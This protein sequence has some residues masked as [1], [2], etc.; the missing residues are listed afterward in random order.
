MS[1]DVARIK[2]VSNAIIAEVRRVG[3]QLNNNG[4]NLNTATHGSSTLLSPMQDTSSTTNPSAHATIPQQANATQTDWPQPREHLSDFMAMFSSVSRGVQP[5]IT[6]E[7]TLSTNGMEAVEPFP[8][9][10]VAIRKPGEPLSSKKTTEVPKTLPQQGSSAVLEAAA[11]K[12]NE[13]TDSG[14]VRPP[15]ANIARRM[16]Q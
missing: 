11:A 9:A 8:E 5:M 13:K 12:L 2:A 1:Q 3:P 15:S 4:N 16:S 10:Y 6:D 14:L 7:I